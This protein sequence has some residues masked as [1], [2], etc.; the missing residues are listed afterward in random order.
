MEGSKHQKMG[1][2]C[3]GLLIGFSW[4]RVWLE[5]KSEVW[6]QKMGKICN[7]LLIGFRWLRVW[8]E[9]KSE[10]CRNRENK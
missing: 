3:N 4:L 8:L 7:G 10:V 9:I 5:I 6:H 2:I 1:K